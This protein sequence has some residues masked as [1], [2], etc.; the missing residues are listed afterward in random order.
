[1][2]G[3]VLLQNERPRPHRGN[4]KGDLL[5]IKNAMATSGSFV[6]FLGACYIGD[7]TLNTR[8]HVS[9]GSKTRDGDEVFWF[10]ICMQD[11]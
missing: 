1:M 10:Q 3:L 2:G 8:D 4:W 9:I 7:Y 6:S 5:M 11:N